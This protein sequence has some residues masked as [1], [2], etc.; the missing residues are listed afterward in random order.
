[1]SVVSTYEADL[2]WQTAGVLHAMTP[3]RRLPHL[4]PQACAPAPPTNH[5]P[6][7]TVGWNSTSL[8]SPSRPRSSDCQE[9]GQFGRWFPDVGTCPSG[10]EEGMPAHSRSVCLKTMQ[11][12]LPRAGLRYRGLSREALSGAPGAGEAGRLLGDWCPEQCCQAKLGTEEA[13]LQ[14]WSRE[15]GVGRPAGEGLLS[16]PRSL[17][18]AGFSPARVSEQQCSTLGLKGGQSAGN[19]TLWPGGG[20]K[21]PLATGTSLGISLP[22]AKSSNPSSRKSCFLTFC[23]LRLMGCG[24]GEESDGNP[25]HE[26]SHNAQGWEEGSFW[27][28]WGSKVSGSSLENPEP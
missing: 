10:R 20:G 28:Q 12:L 21:G 1:M 16:A 8:L 25:F 19:P 7:L 13:Q 2:A 27:I 5:T 3:A 14:A 24:S 26:S 17:P 15:L 9:R 11:R 23:A 6:A 4:A 22:K 18:P